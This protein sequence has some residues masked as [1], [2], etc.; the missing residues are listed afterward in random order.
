MKQ[1]LCSVLSQ[2]SAFS[3]PLVNCEVVL[4]IILIVTILIFTRNKVRLQ[5]FLY[6]FA[7]HEV[8]HIK[9]SQPKID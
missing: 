9:M 5:N 6:S 2:S 4:E 1:S 3:T 7:Y 8:K